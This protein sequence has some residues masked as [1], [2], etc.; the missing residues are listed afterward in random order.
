M[1]V[2]VRR[3][4]SRSSCYRRRRDIIQRSGA[5]RRLGAGTVRS[6]VVM[7][8]RTC[9]QRPRLPP[10]RRTAV[11]AAAAVAAPVDRVVAVAVC[12][13]DITT[14]AARRGRGRGRFLLLEPLFD[15]VELRVGPLPI[16]APSEEGLGP[17]ADVLLGSETLL[18]LLALAATAAVTAGGGG[19]RRGRT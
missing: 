6:V 7:R 15:A 18:L 11:V 19:G 13:A 17:T 10:L 2:H 1:I 14:A 4:S 12:F 3:T 16:P 8:S 9:T 5:G